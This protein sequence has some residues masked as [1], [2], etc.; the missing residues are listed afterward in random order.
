MHDVNVKT[1]ERPFKQKSEAFLEANGCQRYTRG[2]DPYEDSGRPVGIAGVWT[3]TSPHM[4]S[5][6]PAELL[7]S[8]TFGG[9]QYSLFDS[10]QFRMSK[11]RGI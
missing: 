3:Q 8:C 10:T 6:T 11:K 4:K 1:S 7:G 5:S 2:S 9:I